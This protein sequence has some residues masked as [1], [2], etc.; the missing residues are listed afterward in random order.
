[1]PRG[2]ASGR[3][4]DLVAGAEAV[5]LL[6]DAVHQLRRVQVPGLPGW[7]YDRSEVAALARAIKS[8]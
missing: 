7:F 1:M 4:P 3:G 6:G 8:G 2:R 5:R